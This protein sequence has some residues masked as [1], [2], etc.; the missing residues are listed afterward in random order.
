MNWKALFVLGLVLGAIG[1]AMA[2]PCDQL[3]CK[4]YNHSYYHHY[5]YSHDYEGCKGYGHGHCYGYCNGTC[6]HLYC[7]KFCENC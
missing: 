2:Y 1:V 4:D 7:K 3:N 5:N 6:E